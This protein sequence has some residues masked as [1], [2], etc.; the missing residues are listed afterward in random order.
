MPLDLNKHQVSYY[1]QDSLPHRQDLNLIAEQV[2][3]KGI[4]SLHLQ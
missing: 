1:N 2:I 4:Q 3:H